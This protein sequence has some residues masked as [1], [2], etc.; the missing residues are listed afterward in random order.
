MR[1]ESIMTKTNVALI[2]IVLFLSGMIFFDG[3]Q[4]RIEVGEGESADEIYSVSEDSVFDVLSLPD[5]AIYNAF[6]S[7]ERDNFIGISDE[8]LDLISSGLESLTWAC[9]PNKVT[10]L[11]HDGVIRELSTGLEG[12][13]I[14]INSSFG[15]KYYGFYNGTAKQSCRTLPSY[16]LVTCIT[17]VEENSG[18]FTDVIHL[19]TATMVYNHTQIHDEGTTFTSGSCE[20]DEVF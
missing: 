18:P 12:S 5:Q 1:F 19:D 17:E 6:V 4:I 9:I 8:G 11:F 7:G 13:G 20:I 10:N 2:I 14:K 15:W 3:S 16:N